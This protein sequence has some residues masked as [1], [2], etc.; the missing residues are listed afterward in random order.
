MFALVKVAERNRTNEPTVN[1]HRTPTHTAGDA[2]F[3]KVL[4]AAFDPY[5]VP[6]GIEIVLNT[7]DLKVE[8]FNGCPGK[9][10]VPLPFHAGRNLR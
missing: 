1:I 9:D 10:G 4:A 8:F 7:D 2:R 3:F 6:I 5:Y